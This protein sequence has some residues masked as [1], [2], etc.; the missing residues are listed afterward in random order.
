MPHSRSA[1]FGRL[2]TL[3][4]IV[5]AAT[6][7][8]EFAMGRSAF[9]PDGRFGLYDFDIWSSGNSQRVADW[10]ALTHIE[11]GIIFYG[12]LWLAVR[13]WPLAW[14]FTAA[15]LLEAGWEIL[16]NSPIIIDRYREAT[17]ALGYYGDSVLNSVSDVL[18][19]VGGFVLAA[20]LPVWVSVGCLVAFELG[21]LLV[22]RDN[23]ALNIL[24]LLY[25]VDAILRWQM[26]IAPDVTSA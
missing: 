5:L 10:Y 1:S 3:T 11:H 22:I 6:A 15:L 24:M 12:L 26:A 14:R 17:L 2:A 16:E 13:R 23:L 20:R 21:L 8:V 18:M 19:M 9:G 25:P 7:L 4:A